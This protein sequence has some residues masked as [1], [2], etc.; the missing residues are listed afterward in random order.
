MRVLESI[1]FD[2][3]FSRLGDRDLGLRAL[4]LGKIFFN[5]KMV[6]CRRKINRSISRKHG[7]TKPDYAIRRA[8]V[9]SD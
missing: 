6:V 5:L 1:G 4:K 9:S 8:R 7:K 3:K 2:E